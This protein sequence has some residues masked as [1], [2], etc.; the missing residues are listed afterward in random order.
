MTDQ[1]FDPGLLR[2]SILLPLAGVLVAIL[3][4]SVRSRRRAAERLPYG[5]HEKRTSPRLRA[6]PVAVGVA[7]A[8]GNLKPYRGC[9]V[10]CSPDGFLLTIAEPVPVGTILRLH[11]PQADGSSHW[12][13]VWVRH[14]RRG[15]ASWEVG[16]QNL[17]PLGAGSVLRFG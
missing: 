3:V 16:C 5:V 12:V 11:P 17:Q 4:V 14:C 15:D 2:L 1:G 13:P 9:L 8:D 6:G 7:D 10:D